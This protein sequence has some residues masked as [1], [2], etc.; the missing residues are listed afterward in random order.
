MVCVC[1]CL[2]L[3]LKIKWNLTF[4]DYFP[5]LIEI[6][7]AMHT[8]RTFLFNLDVDGGGENI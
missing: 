3:S 1:V 2:L 6:A 5:V 7:I 4:N 8:N